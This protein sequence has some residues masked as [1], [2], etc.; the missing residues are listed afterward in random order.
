MLLLLLLL[1]ELHLL[2]EERAAVLLGLAQRRVVCARA[3][4]AK[5]C[6]WRV[7]WPRRKARS[8]RRRGLLHMRLLH[9]HLLMLVA[10]ERNL[11]LLLHWEELHLHGLQL[12]RSIR[13]GRRAAV[14]RRRRVRARVAQRKLA[15]SVRPKS[16]ARKLKSRHWLPVRATA[17]PA[18][19]ACARARAAYV[20]L[21]SVEL[22]VAW[23]HQ[24]CRYLLVKKVLGVAGAILALALPLAWADCSL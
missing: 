21:D 9:L 19:K 11:L 8:A 20:G 24:R 14:Q 23:Y 13:A 10:E 3:T 18:S 16:E 7:G 12:S 4:R 17:T 5:A 1:L 15:P 22:R 2:R 6:R